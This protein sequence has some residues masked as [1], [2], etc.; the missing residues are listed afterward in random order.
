MEAYTIDEHIESVM[1]EYAETLDLNTRVMGRF[2]QL[3][4]DD[5]VS[6]EL[7]MINAPHQPKE[8]SLGDALYQKTLIEMDTEAIFHITLMDGSDWTTLLPKDPEI[9]AIEEDDDIPF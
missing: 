9:A 6:K 5:A 7:Y 3:F 2:Q 1:G 8:M 4:F